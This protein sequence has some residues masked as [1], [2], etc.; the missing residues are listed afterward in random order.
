[1]KK[2]SQRFAIGATL[3]VDMHAPKEGKFPIARTADGIICFLKRGAKGFFEYGSSWVAE[4]VEIRDKVMIIEPMECTM[5]KAANEYELE[6][7]LEG[8]KGKRIIL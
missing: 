6:K 2:L 3:L 8:M 7:R 5:S 1:M 4:V